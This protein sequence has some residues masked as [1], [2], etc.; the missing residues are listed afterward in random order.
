MAF[1]IRNAGTTEHNFELVDENGAGLAKIAIIAP[2]STERVS[3]TL[4]AGRYS[5][6]CTLPGHKEAGDAGKRD[7]ALMRCAP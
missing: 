3:A 5:Y 7:G 4:V 2:G 6:V 1:A